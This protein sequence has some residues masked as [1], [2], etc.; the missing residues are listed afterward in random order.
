MPVGCGHL[1]NVLL[2]SKLHV[3]HFPLLVMNAPTLPKLTDTRRAF[4]ILVL[5]LGSLT[6]LDASEKLSQGENCLFLGHSFFCPV[7][8]HLPEHTKRA[9]LAA[10]K[11]LV[12]S[13]GGKNGSPGLM[14][15]SRK[16]DIA[17]A[18]AWIE[19]GEVDLVAMTFHSGGES[20]FQHY[21]HWVEFALE[22]NPKARFLIQATWPNKFNRTLPEF[23]GYAEGI[24]ES[25]HEILQQLRQVHPETEFGC[26]P[27]G[28][29]MVGLWRFYE[30]GKLPELAG[31]MAESKK[32][33]PAYLFRDYGGHGGRLA[34]EEGVLLW[35]AAIYSIDLEFYNYKPSVDANLT[36]L[37]KTIFESHPVWGEGEIDQ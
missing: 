12:V 8:R 2:K 9:G 26:V 1:L 30:D 7:V 11:Q 19:T 31:V 13:H 21:N 23:E 17:N 28:H 32:S 35:L 36:G 5:Q 10:H 15:K 27:Q 34:L 18:K 25:V 14:W 20:L 16:E 6:C 29:W 4:V 3:P 22:H 37:I 24:E 33:D